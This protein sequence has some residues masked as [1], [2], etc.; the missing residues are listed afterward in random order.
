MLGKKQK[1]KKHTPIQEKKSKKQTHTHNTILDNFT[2]A[3]ENPGR[4]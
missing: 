3:V 1:N 2:I 4:T